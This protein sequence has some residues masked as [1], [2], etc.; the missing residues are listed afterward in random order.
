MLVKAHGPARLE[1]LGSTKK[2][3]LYT[4]RVILGVVRPCREFS[5]WTQGVKYAYAVP[6]FRGYKNGGLPPDNY[7]F[8]I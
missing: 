1:L 6:P 3:R 8:F 7:V 5:T 4:V 2:R